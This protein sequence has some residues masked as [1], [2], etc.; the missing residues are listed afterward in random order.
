MPA[1]RNNSFWKLRSTH[2]RDKIFQSP[3][4]LWEACCQYFEACE[5]NPLKKQQAFS[6]G[7]RA[8]LPLMRA[9]TL[10]GLFIFLDINRQTW[11]NY[12]K[13]K[14]EDFL[15]I[16]Q[17]VE[18]I[19]YDMKFTG[20]SAGLLKENIIAR[21]LGLADKT[22]FALESLPEDQLDKIIQKLIAKEDDQD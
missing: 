20:A 5:R 14:N 8:T 2:G 19:I 16:I 9:F 3:A 11:E 7:K 1:P 18:T 4:V 21:E 17:K 15:A 13:D 22:G 10:N 12:K 6:N